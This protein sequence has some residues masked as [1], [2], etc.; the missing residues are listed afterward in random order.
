MILEA[1]HLTAAILGETGMGN[2]LATVKLMLLPLEDH[3]GVRE[4]YV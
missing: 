1:T 2:L 4:P 3:G